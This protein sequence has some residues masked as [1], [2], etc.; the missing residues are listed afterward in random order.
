MRYQRVPLSTDAGLGARARI[1]MLVLKTDQTIEFEARQLLSKV[2]GVALHHA[3]LF[4][5]SNITRETLMAMRP[6]I[7]E[8]A[9]LLPV[10]WGFKSIAYACTSGAMV[11]GESEVERL[12]RSV[13]PGARATNPVTAC[14]AALKALG[15][16]RPAI[17]TPYARPVNETIARGLEVRGLDIPS[18]VSFEEP[19]DGVVGR[20]SKPALL[21]AAR[22][23]LEG[24]GTD[25]VFVSC[26]SLRLAD[27]VEQLEQELGVPVTSSNH[28]TIWHLLRLAGIEDRIA[29][30]GRL[31]EIAIAPGLATAAE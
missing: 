28:A 5:D 13:H 19:D 30:F 14:L 23:A 25:G 8:A 1:G 4:N 11:I 21:D 27:A 6:L 31:F 29:G 26:T 12:I 18:F 10:E 24:S 17:V 20:I 16:G 15:V 3:R 22:T 7:A 2:D 9:A